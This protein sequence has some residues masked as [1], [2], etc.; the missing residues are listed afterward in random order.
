[1]KKL[2]T[3]TP[4]CHSRAL[5]GFATEKLAEVGKASLVMVDGA[6]LWFKGA[7]V[8][9]AG[10][11]FP[12]QRRMTLISS[13][14]NQQQSILIYVCS[15]RLSQYEI[16]TRGDSRANRSSL[17]ICYGGCVFWHHKLEQNAGSQFINMDY[18]A[19]PRPYLPIQGIR[20][21]R[22]QA[23]ISILSYS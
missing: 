16:S 4:P 23:A 8:R 6:R 20:N 9:H 13:Q 11:T 18:E 15:K 21:A 7:A 3:T 14:S 12:K 1:M 5:E 19:L 2:T 17:R 22:R 10:G